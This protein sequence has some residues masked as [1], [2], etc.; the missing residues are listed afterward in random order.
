MI[1]I[2]LL[3]LPIVLGLGPAALT[4]LPTMI[5]ATL[6]GAALLTGTN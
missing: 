3:G 6:S 1:A 5:F 4:P 2:G